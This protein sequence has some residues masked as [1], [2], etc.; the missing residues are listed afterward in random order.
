MDTTEHDHEACA[1][2]VREAAALNTALMNQDLREAT[3]PTTV[4]PAG[5]FGGNS[6]SGRTAK[7]GTQSGYVMHRR[8]G[9]DACQPC[10]DAHAAYA[11]PEPMRLDGCTCHAIAGSHASGCQWAM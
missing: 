3:R 1:K 4:K 5:P 8:H 9:Q 10:K 6:Q 7:H 2:L 11:R